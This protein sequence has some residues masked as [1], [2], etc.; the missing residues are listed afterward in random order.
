M[1]LVACP[2]CQK[3]ISSKASTCP[4]CHTG[5]SGDNES[6]MRISHIKKSNQLLNH[7]L[8]SLSLFIFGVVLG[9][10]GGEVATGSRAYIA[11]ACFIFGFIGYLICRIRI[12]LHKRKSV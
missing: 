10:W 1:A 8:L 7:S 3:R 6:H 9:F 11:G 12:V 5:L 2:S 4:H